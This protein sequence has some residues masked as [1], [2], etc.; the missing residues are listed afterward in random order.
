MG[1]N[2]ATEPWRERF[3]QAMAR[4]QSTAA[5]DLA[6]GA[7]FAASHGAHHALEQLEGRLGPGRGAPEGGSEGSR[8][9]ELRTSPALHATAELRA[10]AA[11]LLH[12]ICAAGDA[13]GR[14][15]GLAPLPLA[16]ESA[17]EPERLEL[18]PAVRRAHALLGE[19]V[20][21]WHA[22]TDGQATLA[23][24]AVA[25]GAALDALPRLARP[26]GLAATP[27]PAAA[28]ER[29]PESEP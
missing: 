12:E 7:L 11:A 1:S 16:A 21:S 10:S 4:G 25:L 24:F 18:G 14:A 23:D 28:P 5:A 17:A 13:L 9:A 19:L 3:A 27:S 26:I 22:T 8:T 29:G 2:A 15:L 6:L 20:T